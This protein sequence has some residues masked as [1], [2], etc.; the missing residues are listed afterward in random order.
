MDL[1]PT[2]KIIVQKKNNTFL[3]SALLNGKITFNHADLKSPALDMEQVLLTT[4]APYIKNGFLSFSG[5]DT[6]S[7]KLGN[8]EVS[9]SSINILA[10]GN[11]PG[12]GF[13][14]GLSFTSKGD[15]AFGTAVTFNILTTVSPGTNSNYAPKLSFDRVEIKDIM[16]D[17][18]T[19][20]FKFDGLIKFI[21]NNPTYGKGFFGNLNLSIPGIMP[22]PA[23]ANVWFGTKNTFNY[24][25]FDLAVPYTQVLIEP[26]AECPEGLALYRFMG[27]LYYHMKPAA[28]NQVTQL[29][30]NAFGS[31]QLYIPDST[32]TTGLKGGVTFGTYPNNRVLNGDVAME[33]NFTNAGG[34]NT[35]KL[36]GTA[37]MFVKVEDRV[38]I[39]K[40]NPPVKVGLTATYDFQNS[41][42]H[43]IMNADINMLSVKAHGQAEFHTD[44][45]TWYINFG[46]PQNRVN[47]DMYN[48][49]SLSSY[50]MAG[51]EVDAVPPPP[52]QVADAFGHGFADSRDKVKTA[53]GKGCILG[54]SLQSEFNGEFG[55]NDFSVYY[56][57]G[58]LAGFDLMAYDYGTTLH[59]SGSSSPA[60]L[61]GWYAQGNV[62][63]YLWGTIGAKGTLA[64]DN[65]DVTLASLSAAAL[66]AGKFP[67]PNHLKG[68]VNISYN[69]LRTFKG[70]FTCHF[71]SGSEC[72]LLH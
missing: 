46:T 38:P 44:P 4:D 26:S 3:P 22:T 23:S 29:Y 16:L 58:Y 55:L 68:D 69:F 30:S 9:I 61:N 64:G 19:C 32:N 48:V 33:V 12:I 2:S 27:G 60:G 5:G 25:Y 72:T 6:A 28:V 43:A 65:F 50:I 57:L 13:N 42:L 67:N 36:A 31:A 14:A 34:I 63:A 45:K 51:N 21:N 59:C 10:N 7:A 37:F 53:E 17:I 56:N 49:A 52:Q 71:E 70:S 62:Y 39:I 15:N 54:A 35:M 20:A 47:I 11:K 66:L 8:F 18:K 1:Y 41:I 24:Y 40:T